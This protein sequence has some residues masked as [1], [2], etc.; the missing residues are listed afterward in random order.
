MLSGLIYI[1]IQSITP[2]PSNLTSLY[3]GGTL[4]LK[5]SKKFLIS[6]IGCFFLKILL[7]GLLNVALAERIPGIV[8]Y[9][10]WVGMAYM[11]YLAFKMIRSGWEKDSIISGQKKESTYLTGIVLQ[12]LN[13]KSWLAALTL[14]AV[15]V[16]PV[17]SELKYIVLWSVL[18][19]IVMIISTFLWLFFGTAM[20]ETISRYKKA[21]G[22]IMGLGLIYC[23]V[24]VA[25]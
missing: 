10:K 23:A 14:F 25:L 19:T 15:Y 5:G 22:I 1:S 8:K 16:I 6:D 7:C 4:G 11:L 2:G 18:F 21:F 12:L 24:N 9:I 17:N 3:F 20:K 13:V